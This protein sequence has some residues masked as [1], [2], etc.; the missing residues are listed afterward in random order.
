MRK[1]VS[2]RALLNS[3]LLW[4]SI[5]MSG[6]IRQRGEMLCFVCDPCDSGGL[7]TANPATVMQEYGA[8]FIASLALE[9]RANLERARKVLCDCHFACYERVVAALEAASQRKESVHAQ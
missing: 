3:L 1:Y 7:V 4:L 6:A 5:V 9:Q 8:R 2:K